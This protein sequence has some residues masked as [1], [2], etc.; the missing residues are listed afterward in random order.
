[1]INILFVIESLESGGKERRLVELLKK[2]TSIEGLFK[3]TV[4]LEKSSIHYHEVN[5]LPVEIKVIQRKNNIIYLI[6]SLFFILSK[7]PKI[8][9]TWGNIPT[10]ISILPKILLRAPLLNNQITD[11]PLHLP[12]SRFFKNLNFRF[13]TRIIANSKAGLKAYS[14]PK[15]KS[16][17][18]YN[19][20]NSDRLNGIKPI[21]IQRKILGLGSELVI[22]MVA[23]Y[24]DKK[25]YSTYIKA[26]IQVIKTLDT[27]ISFL[28]VG[29]GD[30]SSLKSDVPIEFRKNILFFS[31][32]NDIESIMNICEL[33][34]LCSFTEGIPN[35]AMEFMALG[36][37]M[38]A[39]SGGG[40]QELIKPDCGFIHS[41]G[42]Y[43]SVAESTLKL[44]RN[45]T[46][47]TRLG[48][49]SKALINSEFSID[50]MT[51]EYISVFKEFNK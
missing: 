13:S 36:K 24:S 46:L 50:R 43:E 28:C 33:G 3:I 16:L 42:D 39:A 29:D 44:L 6:R 12:I 20:F 7:R 31:K 35:S 14:A 19:G 10:L 15:Q 1:M 40:I 41:S 2:I 34:V 18:I 5:S 49:N 27:K 26:A 51:Q 48:Y 23:S 4:L 32:R 22:A 9:S 25:D 11:A 30:Y 38:V 45:P 21:E 37:P 17:V 8:I 47:L